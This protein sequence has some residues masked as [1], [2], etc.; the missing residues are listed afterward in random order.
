MNRAR[1]KHRGSLVFGI[2]RGSFSRV[3]FRFREFAFAIR[4]RSFIQLV[5][6]SD[7]IDNS[8]P[9]G[10][11]NKDRQNNGDPGLREFHFIRDSNLFDWLAQVSSNFWAETFTHRQ[12]LIY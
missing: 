8:A 11:G 1:N 9:G 6:R 2:E 10:C 4:S 12:S 3:L 5:L 7:S